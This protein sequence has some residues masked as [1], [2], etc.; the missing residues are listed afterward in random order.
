[1]EAVQPDRPVRCGRGVVLGVGGRLRGD[2]GVVRFASGSCV[3]DDGERPF[4]RRFLFHS[5]SV[6]CCFYAVELHG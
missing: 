3:I 2:G 1:M 5:V 6:K 4:D